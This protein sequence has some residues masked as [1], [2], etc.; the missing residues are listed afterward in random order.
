M[1]HKLFSEYPVGRWPSGRHM[2]GAV[3][4]LLAALSVTATGCKTDGPAT[5][6]ISRSLSKLP[7]SLPMSTYYGG[8]CATDYT[9]YSGLELLTCV[10][11]FGC[12][13]SHTGVFTPPSASISDLFPSIVS[14]PIDGFETYKTNHGLIAYC[15]G[16][17]TCSTY[18]NGYWCPVDARPSV[19]RLDGGAECPMP[20]GELPQIAMGCST[21]DRRTDG[22]TIA[23]PV[24]IGDLSHKEE[25]PCLDLASR[26]L[27]LAVKIFF[28][29]RTYAQGTGSTN[30]GRGWMHSYGRTAYFPYADGAATTARDVAMLRDSGE[31]YLYRES[32]AGSKTFYP[33]GRTASDFTSRVV[34]DAAGTALSLYDRAGTLE[35]YEKS[36]GRL[37]SIQDRFGNRTVIS[38]LTVVGTSAYI[39]VENWPAGTTTY[40]QRLVME[41]AQGS[42]AGAIDWR[43]VS[44]KDDASVSSPR[45]VSIAWSTDGYPEVITDALGNKRRYGYSG[46]LVNQK[47]DENNVDATGAP[48]A[49]AIRTETAYNGIGSDSLEVSSQ[50]RIGPSGTL[51]EVRFTST[52]YTNG[53]LTSTPD[54]T[55]EMFDGTTLSRTL[56]FNRFG[57]QMN[58]APGQIRRAYN[59]NS[60]TSYTEYVYGS[61]GV[62]EVR[63]PLGRKT[64]YGYGETV[65]L[66]TNPWRDVTSVKQ[67]DSA[68]NV[69]YTSQTA[70]DSY[71]HPILTIDPWNRWRT[72]TYD[73]TT[74]ALKSTAETGTGGTSTALTITYALN[75]YGEV[76]KIKA[77]DGTCTSMSYDKRGPSV[78]VV[79]SNSCGNTGRTAISTTTT[80]DWRGFLTSLINQQGVTTNYEYDAKGRRTASVLDPTGRAVRTE[81]TYD[82]A[83]NLTAMVADAGTGRLNLRT[84][85]DWAFVGM[86]GAYAPIAIREAVGTTAARTTNLTYL[87]TGELAS[88]VEVS[89][90]NRTTTFGT[91]YNTD[92]T[93]T[94]T[95][96]KPGRTASLTTVRNAAGQVTSTNDELGVKTATTY[97]AYGRLSTTTQGAQATGTLPVTFTTTYA[98]DGSVTTYGG[99]GNATWTVSSIDAYG[100]ANVS[101]EA[102]LRNT[103]TY[104]DAVGRVRLVRRADNAGIV[105]QTVRTDYDGAGRVTAMVVD[106]TSVG[107]GIINA[108]TLPTT[109]LN[110]TTTYTYVEGTDTDKWN[111]RAVTDA[112]GNVT[113]YAYN[114]LALLSQT[115]DAAGTAFTYT[116]DNLGR[117]LQVAGGGRTQTMVVD[118]LGRQISVAQ[119]GRTESWT[120]RADGTKAT[121]VQFAGTTDP[122][123]TVTYSYES[124]TGR[125][126]SVNYPEVSGVT[127]ADVSYSYLGNDLLNQIVDA[128]GT[129]TYTYDG[130]NRVA[131]KK[132]VASTGTS[133][134]LTYA[135]KANDVPRA[136]MQYWTSGTVGYGTDALGRLTSMT[137]WSGGVTNYAYAS[138]NQ[139]TSVSANAGTA[140]V[141][142]YGYDTARRVINMESKKGTTSILQLNYKGSSTLGYGTRTATTLLG[143]DNVGN[144][145]SLKEQWGTETVL[146]HAYSYDVLNR[147]VNIDQPAL[148]AGTAWG[149]GALEQSGLT[150]TYDTTGNATKMMSKTYTYGTDDR[151][152][153]SGYA[154]NPRGELTTS[155]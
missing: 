39:Y 65:N 46:D 56:R 14:G 17:L 28:D 53:T 7:S 137:D 145:Q 42:I 128:N 16:G 9:L 57:S 54:L 146:K 50:K 98:S 25:V 85:T 87:A 102:G 18:Y 55:V 15:R 13:C 116:Y 32:A 88:Q 61:D 154:V 132:R 101:N 37:Q 149:A 63:D 130:L 108:P 70:Y 96:T 26:G 133:R 3:G 119:S 117:T 10:L 105:E 150:N 27:P 48:L 64:L 122:V 12:S 6:E 66:V 43:L 110:L 59:A 69:I 134:T 151:I 44:V 99:N 112:K 115:T 118:A 104:Y 76:T 24:N 86:E 20:S 47:W 33:I 36:S 75:S 60:T 89:M 139:P 30:L 97:D 113:K 1:I 141:Q 94:T 11:P 84:E 68:G 155:P 90:S 4:V 45:T 31:V 79:D 125:L 127:S 72:M 77:A 135:Y 41:H 153:T 129:S 19:K 62:S 142:S 123:Q 124:T 22:P 38:A 91:T 58:V 114:S 74:G 107:T 5:S 49:T 73:A 148:P 35:T 52:G 140:F 21:T 111:L 78:T 93:V 131:T 23:N 67:A 71:G 83:G 40:N 120:Y 92:G 121:M 136:S 143:L 103:T 152:T 2:G 147:L 81:Y 100:R 144:V 51:T 8:A 138:T 34:E 82:K 126:S 29:T 80:F 95:V 106:P 109:G